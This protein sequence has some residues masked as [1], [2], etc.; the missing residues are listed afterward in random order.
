MILFLTQY[1]RGIGHA[2]RVKLLAEE[3]AK[4]TPTIV[5]DQLFRPPLKI[6]NVTHYAMLESFQLKDI[7]K[8]FNFIQQKE[9]IRFRLNK[10]KTILREHRPKVV[11]VEGFPFCRHQFAYEYFSYIKIAKESGAKLICSV[12]DYPWDEPHES[13]VQDWIAT[14]QNLVLRSF[15]EKVLVH[16]DDKILPL[17]ADRVRITN[18]KELI[19]EIKDMIVYTGYVCDKSI[20]KHDTK[21]N[22]VYVSCG[23]NKEEVLLIF[24][25][26]LKVAEKFPDLQFVM[27]MANSYMEKLS[28]VKKGNVILTDYIPQLSKKMANCKLLIAYGGYNTTMEILQG[29]CP[30]III[31]RQNGQKVEQFVRAYAFEPLDVFKVC[32]PNELRTLPKIIESAIKDESFPKPFEYSMNGVE[33]S[34]K[35]ILN[36]VT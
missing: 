11:I 22:H 6:E 20:P 21:N 34:A 13:S 9:L 1:Y 3:T 2:N 33:N 4:H 15:F 18:T 24:K 14:T 19:D 28:N 30:A 29:E 25:Q 31:P 27:T 36:H 8:I 12:R 5:V 7:K 26:I 16:G 23:L 32:N 10:W 35:E 17:M